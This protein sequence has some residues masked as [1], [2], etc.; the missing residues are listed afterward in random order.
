M[1]VAVVSY[2]SS[3]FNA[4][5]SNGTSTSTGKLVSDV[6]S[7][8]VSYASDDSSVKALP[9]FVASM[10]VEDEMSSLSPTL[11]HNC[12]EGVSEMK[13]LLCPES[14]VMI[15]LT[16]SGL[17]SAVV[18]W[19]CPVSMRM[20]NVLSLKD[21][22]VAS[23]SYCRA[24]QSSGSSVTC[25]CGLD[26]SAEGKN[27]SAA[28]SSILMG[29]GGAV[30]LAVMT[31]FV[32]GDFGGTVVTGSAGLSGN[33]AQQSVI[34]M[35][36]FGL[37][38]GFGLLNI[39][40]RLFDVK[41]SEA[42]KKL[43]SSLGVWWAKGTGKSASVA[44]TEHLLTIVPVTDVIQSTGLKQTLTSVNQALLSSLNDYLVAVLPSI[45]HPQPWWKRLWTQFLKHH[46][47]MNMFSVFWTLTH[48]NHR[49]VDKAGDKGTAENVAAV[50][51]RSAT[52]E[53]VYVL[54][55]V[56]ISCFTLALLYDLQYPA[57]DGSCT[58]HQDMASCL[59][60]KTV[61]DSSH[62][63]CKWR[64]TNVDTP[65]PGYIQESRYG[66]VIQTI[67]LETLLDSNSGN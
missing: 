42:H 35:V 48:D 20:C 41:V 34:V 64:P 53:V 56:T 39:C 29:S 45:F 31:K 17:S 43:R 21:L 33:I 19:K 49:T 32:A 54:T 11:H 51:H 67:P 66:H 26:D 15:N 44:K 38:W 23:D 47:S 60:R 37:F 59:S 57:D 62:S 55:S 4:V 46:R 36:T 52:L 28:L 40:L 65:S 6:L 22:S 30:N 5:A 24:V 25:E 61:L 3:L 16:C 1:A 18:R 8:Q 2:D 13:S 58:V 7:I 12:T 9:S 50:M 14:L 10:S 27:A 63:Y